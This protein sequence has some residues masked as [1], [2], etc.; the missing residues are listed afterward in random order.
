MTIHRPTN[1][2]HP[3]QRL[4]ATPKQQYGPATARE[5]L[6]RRRCCVPQEERAVY[7]AW[8]AEACSSMAASGP[9]ARANCDG[10]AEY[11]G[12]SWRADCGRLADKRAIRRETLEETGLHVVEVMGE[13]EEMRVRDKNAAQDLLN[14]TAGD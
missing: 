9:Q 2:S 11:V 6:H 10:I 7:L 14:R 8:N 3:V 1:P 12:A 13:F 5:A 4:P